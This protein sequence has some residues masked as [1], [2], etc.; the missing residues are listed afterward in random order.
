MYIFTYIFWYLYHSWHRVP[1]L[2]TFWKP[3][4]YCLSTL[5]SNFVLHLPSHSLSPMLFLL[6]CFFDWIGHLVLLYCY[7]VMLL[8]VMM[9]LLLFLKYCVLLNLI[10]KNL[11]CTKPLFFPMGNAVFDLTAYDLWQD[12]MFSS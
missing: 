7:D 9:L 8:D 2:P 5:F 6:P 1:N 3:H 12:F 10:K 4:L 11:S